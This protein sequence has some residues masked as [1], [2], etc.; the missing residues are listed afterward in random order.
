MQA[1]LVL[2]IA[3]SHVYIRFCN[4]CL[5]PKIFYVFGEKGLTYCPPYVILKVQ[6]ATKGAKQMPTEKE[7]KEARKAVA[8]DLINIIE[9]KPEQTTFTAEE[10]KKLIKT[11]VT[12]ANQD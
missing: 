7:M 6:T 10:I 1:R 9:Q 2:S 5:F 8:H 12:T 11:Y 4:V 3:I